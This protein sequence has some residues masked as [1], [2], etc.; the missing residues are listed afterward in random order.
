[1]NINDLETLKV[2]VHKEVPFTLTER[3]DL[4]ETVNAI[5]EHFDK[6]LSK[7]SK[8]DVVNYVRDYIF[9]DT[10]MEDI[11]MEVFPEIDFE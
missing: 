4:I 5:E 6:P 8:Y 9:D 2:I 3:V 10:L 7:L 11:L 1:M